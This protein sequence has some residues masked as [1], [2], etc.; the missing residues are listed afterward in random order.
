MYRFE[1]PGPARKSVT[2]AQIACMWQ[3]LNTTIKDWLS[4]SGSRLI[5]ANDRQF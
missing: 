4:F 3:A 5:F 2:S 1:Q